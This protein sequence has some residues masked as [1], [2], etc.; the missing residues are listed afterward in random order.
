MAQMPQPPKPGGVDPILSRIMNAQDY[1]A[2]WVRMFLYGNSRSGKTSQAVRFPRPFMIGAPVE[3]GVQ[4]ARG[5]DMPYF[6]PGQLSKFDTRKDMEGLLQRLHSDMT[7]LNVAR[8]GGVLFRQTWGDTFIWD[9]VTHY[10]DT[11]L[12]DIQTVRD[13]A[14]VPVL[15]PEM[16]G[17]QVEGS[18][19]QT[20]GA[21]R[22]HLMNVRDI[23]FRLPCHV[24][25]TAL[26]AMTTDEKGNI[27]WQ[28]PRVQGAAGDLIPSSCELLGMC[29]VMGGQYVCHFQKVGKAEA[30]TRIPGM[31]QT[32]LK[33]G[34]EPGT[35]LYD[36]LRPWIAQG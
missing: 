12:D 28:G 36:Q 5:M 31:A 18:N 23:L 19:K 15:H 30:G 3:D 34:L 24:I 25:I 7:R 13:K 1:K 14:G 9:A 2:P 22:S 29:D 27:T 10:A 6:I 35:T 11:V 26:D 4:T 16:G 17:L 21:L 8:D 20:W 33:I 32:T